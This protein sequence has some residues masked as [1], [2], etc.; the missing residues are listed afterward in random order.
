[1]R[2]HPYL[3]A[4]MAGIAVPTALLLVMVTVFAIFRFYLLPVEQSQAPTLGS[5][6][7]LESL[8]R[9][10]IFPMAVVPNLWGIWN[11]SYLAVRQRIA[12]PLGLYGALLPIVIVPFGIALAH[13]FGIFT[14]EARW[15]VPF[16][17]TAMIAYYLLWKHVVGLLNHEM[18][19]A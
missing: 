2:P 9:A 14:L 4:Y 17:A 18:G 7:L 16:A 5:A 6:L 1:M 3:R 13:A 12:L 11:M 15:V 8:G 10:I 19:I